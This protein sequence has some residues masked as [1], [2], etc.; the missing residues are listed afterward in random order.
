[1]YIPTQ[2]ERYSK[3]GLLTLL[4][5]VIIPPAAILYLK[6]IHDL[7][8]LAGAFTVPLAW[9]AQCAGASVAAATALSAAVQA[10]GFFLLVRRTRLAPK[11]KFTLCITWGMLTALMLKIILVYAEYI[12]FLGA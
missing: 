2:E 10:V 12:L 1:M 6:G 5:C 4:L 7:A 8:Q 9:L 3:G 11:T